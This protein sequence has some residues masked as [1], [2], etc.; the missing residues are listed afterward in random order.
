M[1][2]ICR[3]WPAVIFSLFISVFSQAAELPAMLKINPAGEVQIG[4]GF[5]RW[6]YFDHDWNSTRFD[7]EFFAPATGFPQRTASEFL[8]HGE[9]K[10]RTVPGRFKVNTSIAADTA[11]TVKYSSRFQASPGIPTNMLALIL[12][13]PMHGREITVMIDGKPFSIPGTA[14][15]TILRPRGKIEALTVILD[16]VEVTFGGKYLFYI[17][18]DRTF[19]GSGVS[20]RFLPSQWEEE[21][22]DSSLDLNI[23]FK[24]PASTP[25]NL[26]AVANMGFKDEV[27]NDGKGGWSDQGPDNDMR[28]FDIARK[29]YE[30]IP[31][32]I[33]DPATNGGRAVISFDSEHLRNGLKRA[34]VDLSQ[35][36]PAASYLYLLHTSCWN[37]EPNGTPV[38]S[39]S[40]TF[41]DG[42]TIAKEVKTGV[43][44]MDWWAAGDL[45]N[46][47]VVVRKGGA[48][49]NVG[50]FLSKFELSK[51]PRR[52]KSIEFNSNGKAIW[53][54][55][56]ATLSERDVSLAARTLTFYGNNEWKAVDMSDIQIKKG[57]ALDLSGLLEEGPAGKHGRL[58]VSKSG[59]LAFEDSPD[60]AIRFRGFNSF[61]PIKRIGD[62]P[63]EQMREQIAHYA[64]LVRGSGYDLVRPLYMDNY[65]MSGA[66]ADAQYNPD[67]LDNIDWLVASL[68]AKG[69]YTYASIAAYR[70]GSADG[71]KG[72]LERDTIKLKM[73]L[74]DPESRARWKACAENLLNHVNPYTGNAWKNEPAIAVV[75]PYNEQETAFLKLGDLKG[76]TLRLCEQKWG[77]WLKSKYGTPEK[78]A[79]E[80]KDPSIPPDASFDSMKLPSRGTGFL[81][82]EFILFRQSMAEECFSWY[83]DIIRG[84]GY[85]GLISQYNFDQK[86]MGCAVRW[87]SCEAI[88][89]NGYFAH[90][91]DTINPGSKCVQNSSAGNVGGYWRSMNATRF[92]DRPFMNTEQKQ[93]FWN[94]YRHEDGLLFASY[95][96]FQGFDSVMVHCDPVL[97][98]AEPNID[99]IS[100]YDPVAMANEF[101]SACLYK[102][103]DVKHSEKSVELLIPAGYVNSSCNGEK[104]ISSTQSRIALLTGFSIA[105]AELKKPSAISSTA[106]KPDLIIGPD[107]GS[108]VKGSAWAASVAESK[109]SKFNLKQFVES[110]K[111]ND[112]LPKS[113]ISDPENEI[114]Q[115]GTGEIVLRAKE[116]LLKVVTPKSEGVS[117]ESGK[118]EQLSCLNVLNS[119]TAAS[120]AVCAIDGKPLGA[121]SR[122]VLIYATDAV[123]S[124]MEF[125]GDRITLI[126]PGSLP[127]L[128]RTGKL[129]ATLKSSAPDGMKL[130]ALGMDGTRKENLPLKIENGLL[131]IEIDTAKLKNGA[132]PFFEIANN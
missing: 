72:W 97:L 109:D 54:V 132:T 122:I 63:K 34:V 62:V 82:N 9:W 60:T 110:L 6:G 101:I 65:I 50:V 83:K 42:S 24:V 84:I 100:A 89:M 33:I 112:I 126:K 85:R 117:L 25:V 22:T 49:A 119:S 70:V 64:D 28:T 26:A 91:T 96:A 129:N 16:G 108:E 20:L 46:A 7:Q 124:G 69:I 23:S 111:N 115:S 11:G 45:A 21:V 128:M 125:S 92:S 87:E 17:Q 19:G 93:A 71:R 88:S 116:N 68:K 120:V 37:Q 27:A 99:F 107:S 35:V 44:L 31:F 52:I 95:S 30:G 75:E 78:L 4:E 18:D 2:S 51:T 67:K 8:L 114:F 77:A 61:W 131:K 105:F 90:P 43:D 76:D 59:H 13:I 113:N 47:K 40:V 74:G 55:A 73:Y 56:G 38:G 127:I 3:K 123:N 32:K 36:M 57:S 12:F 29:D 5:L 48:S 1:K 104:A 98:K 121:S 86:L 79:A 102:R 41:D 66:V 81:A 106:A 58:I 94:K 80:G 118:A 130:F 15:K 53:I 14:G 103:G 39:I 10:L